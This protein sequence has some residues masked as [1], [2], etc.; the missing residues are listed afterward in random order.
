[1][2]NRAGCCGSRSGRWKC[3]NSAISHARLVGWLAGVFATHH[4][5]G[6]GRRTMPLTAVDGF[7]FLAICILSGNS[8]G[9]EDV[10]DGKDGSGKTYGRVTLEALAVT[11][12]P[13]F[14]P[15]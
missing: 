2:E 3:S 12:W 5:L 14:P 11:S 9:S 15:T 13:S 6:P 8:C 7:G 10:L 4:S 1:M